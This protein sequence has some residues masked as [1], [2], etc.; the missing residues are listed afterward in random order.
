MKTK[1]TNTPLQALVLMNDTQYVEAARKVAERVLREAGHAPEAGFRYASLLTLGRPPRPEE[2]NAL[3]A[4]Y[5]AQQKH[6]ADRPEAALQLLKAGESAPSDS[7]D[8]TELAAW[9]MV[10]NALMNADAAMSQF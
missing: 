9:T 7:L 10:A 6:Y 4:L 8:M 1:R 3:S 5:A 2:V